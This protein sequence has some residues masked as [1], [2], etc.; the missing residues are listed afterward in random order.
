M[1]TTTSRE[2]DVA[3]VAA[4]LRS[5]LEQLAGAMALG[6][7]DGVLAAEPM[8]QAAVARQI[9]TMTAIAAA[10]RALALRELTGARVALARCRVLGA[11]AAQVTDAALAAL[12]RA[13]SYSRQGAGPSRS[14]RG[15]GLKARV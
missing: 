2:A 13:P 1:T 11:G 6:D 9:T 3:E 8:L 14:L 5:A 4:E 15:R 12:G 10:D 7:A